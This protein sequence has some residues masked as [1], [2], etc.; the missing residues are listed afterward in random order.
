MLGDA[1]E[2]DPITSR[3]G[4][5]SRDFYDVSTCEVLFVNLLGAVRVSVGTIFEM[6][7]GYA[8]HKQ[9]VLV[10]EENSNC[11]DHDFV[12]EVANYTVTTLEEGIRVTK[13]ILLPD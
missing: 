8:L 1:I 4:I 11:M 12:R 3:K 10:I 5:L 9:I 2:N 13:A 7:W 6:A